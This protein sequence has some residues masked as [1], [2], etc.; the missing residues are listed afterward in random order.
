MKTLITL[1]FFTL[2]SVLCGKFAPGKSTGWY[3]ILA[4]I[5]V[6]QVATALYLMFTMESPTS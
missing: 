6:L 1:L 5:T 3:V 2:L 4:V